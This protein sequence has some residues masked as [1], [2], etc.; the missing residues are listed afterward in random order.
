M[1]LNRL[2]FVL[3][4]VATVVIATGCVNTVSGRKSAAVPLIKDRVEGRYERPAGMVF[5]AAKEV[6]RYNGTIVNEVTRHQTNGYIRA[7]EGKVQERKVF[8]AVSEVDPKVS[9]VVVQVR[10]TAGGRDLDLAHELEKQ[11]A[12]KLV[13]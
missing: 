2:S 6:V 4:L 11:I 7:L 1:K 9:S 5:E 8:I 13:R 10:T 3:G 12:L